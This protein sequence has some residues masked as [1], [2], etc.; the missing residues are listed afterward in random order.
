MSD[1]QYFCIPCN[2]ISSTPAGAPWPKCFTC[3]G[4]TVQL[5]Q[6]PV[7]QPKNQDISFLCSKCGLFNRV[8]LNVYPIRCTDCSNEMGIYD[9]AIIK[10]HVEY[11]KLPT[12]FT[13]EDYIASLRRMAQHI[14]SDDKESPYL[15]EE[16][17]HLESL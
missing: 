17:K 15:E 12:P 10:E 3:G 13:R 14:I 16:I 2:R 4:H 8:P 6:Q 5:T 1:N 7:H 9:N 11:V